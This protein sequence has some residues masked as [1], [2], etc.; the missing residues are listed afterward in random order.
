MSIQLKKAWRFEASNKASNEKDPRLNLNR[1]S[2]CFGFKKPVSQRHVVSF[3]FSFPVLCY[4]QHSL[5]QNQG[6][7]VVCADMG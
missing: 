7:T 5:F 6:P 4:V 1:G 3:M 2:F